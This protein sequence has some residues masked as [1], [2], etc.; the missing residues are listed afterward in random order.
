MQST[1]VQKYRSRRTVC[2]YVWV[3]KQ[4]LTNKVEKQYPNTYS[5]TETS[6]A[7]WSRLRVY[8]VPSDLIDQSCL[9]PSSSE[10]LSKDTLSHG[11]SWCKI[12]TC[13]LSTSN[14]RLLSW[15]PHIYARISTWFKAISTIEKNVWYV[16]A[17]QL[18]LGSG[19]SLPMQDCKQ[20]TEKEFMIILLLDQWQCE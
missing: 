13:S 2:A 20:H 18:R 6:G 19:N 16:I 12:L 7:V 3:G 8:S 14:W 5:D 15:L 9:S 1:D 11:D 17:Q 10:S 4:E